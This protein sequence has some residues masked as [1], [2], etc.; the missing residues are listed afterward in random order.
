MIAT[1]DSLLLDIAIMRVRMTAGVR[2]TDADFVE[3]DH[4]REDD[5]KFTE[6]GGGAASAEQSKGQLGPVTI[7]DGD[8]HKVE[9]L[10]GKDLHAAAR[11]LGEGMPGISAHTRISS[12]NGGIMFVT[13]FHGEDGKEVGRASRGFDAANSAVE[14]KLFSIEPSEQGKGIGTAYLKNSIDLYK[15]AGVKTVRIKA[16]LDNGAYTWAKLGFT[17]DKKSWD[18]LRDGMST[19]PSVTKSLSESERGEVLS[20]LANPDPKGIWALA[21]H[22]KGKKVLSGEGWKGG[23]DLADPESYARLTKATEKRR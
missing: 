3:A 20:L 12:Q 16:S 14:H 8:G 1:V 23:F 6:A 18:T 13:Q 22:P 21:D 2:M 17:P 5:G 7:D 4:P 15:A 10:F 11:K 19:D 9:A